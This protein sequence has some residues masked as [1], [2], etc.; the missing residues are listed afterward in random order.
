MQEQLVKKFEFHRRRK[1]A[2]SLEDSGWNYGV[3]SKALKEVFDIWQY[4][5]VLRDRQRF[6]NKFEHFKTNVQGLD[7][8]FVHVK[9]KVEEKYEV[10][11]R[12]PWLN[13][14]L[15]NEDLEWVGPPT[16][17]WQTQ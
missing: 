2:Q 3:N 7:V 16:T 8:H 4:K 15:G 11:M 13:W 9:P 14:F 5:Y 6:L 1:P 17:N 10:S 12:N